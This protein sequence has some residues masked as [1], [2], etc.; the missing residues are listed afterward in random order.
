[1]LDVHHEA[2]DR[3]AITVRGHEFFVDQPRE[4]GGEDTAP[5][6]VEVFVGALA[7]CVAHY[8]RGYL[9]R[10]ELPTIGL[11]VTA[12]F[13]MDA[14]PARVG[15]VRLHVTVPDGVPETRRDALLAV[16]SACTV[17]NSLVTPPEVSVELANVVPAALP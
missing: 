7:S 8:A 4:A 5:T 10:H 2:Q 11:S 15:Q 6:P 1:M 17:H 16:A 13:D 9:L 3:W 14:R 12:T